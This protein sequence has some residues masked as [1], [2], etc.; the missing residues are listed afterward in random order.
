M[1]PSPRTLFE[2]IWDSHIVAE[3]ED[4]LSLLYID[5]HLV[6]EVTSPQAFTGLRSAGRN[7]RRPELP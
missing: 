1:I 5:C 7:V 4:G 6:N 3:F 2:K